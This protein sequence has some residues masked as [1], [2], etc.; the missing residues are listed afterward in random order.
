MKFCNPLKSLTWNSLFQSS[1]NRRMRRRP[2][3]APLPVAAEVLEVRSLLSSGNVTASVVGTA[4][5]MTSDNNGDHGV[6]CYR[7]D[8]THVEIDGDSGTTINGSASA[9]FTLSSVF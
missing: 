1:R 2:T 5:T 4:L 6:E 8:A 7:L 9:V 3:Y